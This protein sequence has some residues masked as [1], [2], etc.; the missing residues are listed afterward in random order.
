M[1]AGA[2]HVGEF[3]V[4]GGGGE[5]GKRAPIAQFGRRR[6]KRSSVSVSALLTSGRRLELSHVT[7]S[8]T[9][10]TQY[11][12]GLELWTPDHPS[13]YGTGNY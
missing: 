9:S 2:E 11:G 8:L 12:V 4:L 7:A 6:G 10:P 13:V 5:I 3:L 1:A